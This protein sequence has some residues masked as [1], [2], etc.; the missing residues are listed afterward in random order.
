[1]RCGI[2]T[3]SSFPTF[4][5]MI[6][7]SDG[8]ENS[9]TKNRN[10][11][12]SQGGTLPLEIMYGRLAACSIQWRACAVTMGDEDG[13][14]GVRSAVRC[15][16]SSFSWRHYVVSPRGP[17]ACLERGDLLQKQAIRVVP[18]SE[19]QSGW[20]S[21]YFLVPKSDGTL[22]PILDLHVLNMHLKVA[23]SKYSHFSGYCSHCVSQRLVHVHRS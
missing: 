11:P 19:V 8:Y 4:R 6:V 9:L 12:S 2:R 18:V 16:S 13:N 22:R 21:S 1:M 17:S 10:Y 7:K 20:Y 5:H 23:S 14:K 15:E 3:H